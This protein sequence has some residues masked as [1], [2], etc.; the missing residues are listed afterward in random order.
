[1]TEQNLENENVTTKTEP[2]KNDSFKEI[3]LKGLQQA[4]KQG[5]QTVIIL[6]TGLVAIY[7]FSSFI[8]SRIEK[9]VT[10][11]EFMNKVA[12]RVRPSVIFDDK[13]TIYYDSGAM[14]FLE[15]LKVNFKPT[16]TNQIGDFIIEVI[17][18]EHLAYPPLLEAVT[19]NDIFY[20]SK[21]GEKHKWLIEGSVTSYRTN[22]KGEKHELRLRLEI[23]Q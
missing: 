7:G 17:P 15:D 14:Q 2:S 1:M 3:F 16:A 21:R 22:D 4:W 19:D 9:A 18:K 11:S 10:S 12:K 6:A 13:G 23:L 5:W 8:D 20:E